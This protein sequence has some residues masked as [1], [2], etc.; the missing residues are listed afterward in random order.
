VSD[1]IT[2]QLLEWGVLGL[3]C[4]VLGLTVRL[5]WQRYDQV[6]EARLNEQK[7]HQ[8]NRVSDLK[9]IVDVVNKSSATYEAMAHATADR[10]RAT[11]AVASAQQATAKALERHA[12]VIKETLNRIEDID[13]AQ[14]QV[15]SQ[16][17]SC[18]ESM[19]KL[20]G[21]IEEMIAVM[22]RGT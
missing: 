13:R 16:A 4:L 21:R 12:D 6:Q 5:L 15:I 20:T 11:D 3:A 10:T 7:V 19:H 2:S 18:Q 1:G 14:E 9:S 17:N 22:R 8:E